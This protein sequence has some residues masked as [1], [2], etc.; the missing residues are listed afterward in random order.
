[1]NNENKKFHIN[2]YILVILSFLLVILVGSLLLC[3][4][5]ARN[6]GTWGFYDPTDIAYH[7]G[8]GGSS[9]IDHLFN[10]VS[11]TCVTGVCSFTADLY[12]EYTIGG[13]IVM[14]CMIQIGGLGFI[15]V[16]TFIL[17][18]F[19]KKIQFKDRYILAQAVNST[20]IADVVIFVRRIIII[21]AIVEGTG[22][23]IALPG[24]YFAC[25]GD[26]GKAIWNSIFT[27]ISSFNNAGFDVL[28]NTSFVKEGVLSSSPDWAYYY[29]VTLSATLIILGG[30][31]FLVIIEIVGGKK[32][33]SQY[34][35][36]TKI[37]LVSTAFLLIGGF[38][39]F[40]VTEVFCSNNG[41]NPFDAFYLS[42]TCRTAGFLTKNPHDMSTIG[43]IF[44]CFLMYV[45][46]APLGTAGGIK[47]TTIYMIVLA[48][49]CYFRGKPVSSFKRVYSTQM[50]IKAMS[51]FI[52]S[53]VVLV[54]AFVCVKNFEA[55]QTYVI[56]GETIEYRTE[57]LF[58]EVTSAFGTTGFTTTITTHLR[59]G[60]KIVMCILMFLGRLGPM[61]FFQI[62]QTNIS[63]NSDSHIKYV[64]EDF[65]IG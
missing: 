29:V 18:L 50:V 35:A 41:Y 39:V 44:S 4:P 10:A 28:G 45:G 2:P 63:K 17:T 22:I 31:S 13:Q 23:L 3:M 47:I 49:I 54:V 32:R 34:R 46:G 9:Y 43:K 62:F 61:T 7:D 15:T 65:L 27:V 51:L 30:L 12:G 57:D 26:I 16:L 20:S 48:M 1:M 37:I 8:A 56:N 42:V 36:F 14:L 60:S 53:L 25:N 64:E 5:W 19:K 33:P 11:A 52:I 58:L 59:F 40:L 6:A 38:L 55:G 24:F 21:S